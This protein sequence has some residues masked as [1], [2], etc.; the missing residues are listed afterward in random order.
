MKLQDLFEGPKGVW[1]LKNK[2]GKEKRFKDKN[3]KEAQ[4]WMNSTTPKKPST[5]RAYTDQYWEDKE[6]KAND[7][8]FVTPWK[9]IGDSHSDSVEI[10]RIVKDHFGKI[11]TDWTFEKA[12]ETQVDGTSCATRV[13]RVMFEVTPEDDMGVDDTVQDA[14]TIIV[15]RDRQKPTKIKF[16]RYGM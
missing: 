9:K 4:E 12:G 2:D 11:K 5:A 14:Q 6:W 13:V 1:V 7:H 3:S 10:E 8:S 16:L 15:V